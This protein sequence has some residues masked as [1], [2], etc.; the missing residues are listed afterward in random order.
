MDCYKVAGLPVILFWT[1]TQP[2]HDEGRKLLVKMLNKLLENREVFLELAFPLLLSLFALTWAFG[3]LKD[4]FKKFKRDDSSGDQK[5]QDVHISLND[6]QKRAYRNYLERLQ[7]IL[8]EICNN[9]STYINLRHRSEIH[10]F[11][12]NLGALQQHLQNFTQFVNPIIID[13]EAKISKIQKEK[14]NRTYKAIGSGVLS[15]ALIGVAVLVGNPFVRV[16]SGVVG[17][18]SGVYSGYNVYKIYKLKKFINE[19]EKV[20][21]VLDKTQSL[22]G[23]IRRYVED[24]FDPDHLENQSQQWFIIDQF[25]D[26]RNEV[27]KMRSTL[28]SVLQ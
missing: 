7:I 2:V 11:N 8:E 22:L 16:P 28:P 12:V 13:L 1:N 3:L 9:L 19:L 21:D 27:R 20:R 25:K 23:N 10:Q 24:I 5:K 15:F 14:K 26:F 4:A 17:G 6:D 18:G